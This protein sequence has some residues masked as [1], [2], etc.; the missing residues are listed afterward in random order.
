MPG[1]DQQLNQGIESRGAIYKNFIR[2]RL[3][4]LYSSIILVLRLIFAC[5][6]S[7]TIRQWAGQ[8]AKD[9][10]PATTQRPLYFCYTLFHFCAMGLKP[11]A[12][13]TLILIYVLSESLEPSFQYF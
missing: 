12:N 1:E 5:D 11:I 8:V 3:L 2:V 4:V 7:K 10:H 13:D 9:L 6:G